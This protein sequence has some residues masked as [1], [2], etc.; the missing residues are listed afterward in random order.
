MIRLDFS[1]ACNMACSELPD[2]WE[3]EIQLER[4]ISL[5]GLFP[6]N[7]ARQD[8]SAPGMTMTDQFLKALA[9]AKASNSLPAE[10]KRVRLKYQ[11]R[12]R[13]PCR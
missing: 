1:T 12:S 11:S 3:I 4:G 5:L 7:G 10:S 2:G 13:E 8:F 6:P 9:A